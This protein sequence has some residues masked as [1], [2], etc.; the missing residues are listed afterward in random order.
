MPQQRN[1]GLAILF[2]IITCGIYQLY[3][4]YQISAETRDLTG[5][6]DSGSP[7]LDLLLEIV[8]CGIYGFFVIYQ[9]GKRLYQAELQK[10]G[11]AND[12]SAMLTVLALFFWI[13]SL[14]I[15]QHKLNN[16]NS[17]EDFNQP[18]TV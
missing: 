3:W 5:N 16:F 15:I 6:T 14:A 8:T 11:T 12:D 10:K 4:L 7:G 2:S 18:H 13:V 9:C 1:I 17:F